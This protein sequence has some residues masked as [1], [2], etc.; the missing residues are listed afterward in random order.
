MKYHS[1]NNGFCRVNYIWK[2][3]KGQKIYYCIQPGNFR[4]DYRVYECSQDGEPSHEVN[5][6]LTKF[7][8]SPGTESMDLEVNNWLKHEK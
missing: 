4:N 2:N 3:K 5:I 1:T 7:P 8:L 6:P